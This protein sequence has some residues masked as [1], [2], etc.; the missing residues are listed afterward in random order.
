[1]ILFYSLI[2]LFLDISL[3]RS[4]E[5]VTKMVAIAAKL[6][7][8]PTNFTEFYVYYLAKH[9]SQA[10]RR[11][12]FLGSIL[13]GI[14]SVIGIATL[15]TTLALCGL[16]TGISLCLI[17]DIAVQQIK[18]TFVEYPLWSTRANFKMVVNMLKGTE[19]I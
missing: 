2:S 13:G 15:N 1:M 18:P 5:E 11:L 9:R 4:K 19:S 17:G 14:I 7:I 8:R 10:C 6:G 12:H 16:A 3:S